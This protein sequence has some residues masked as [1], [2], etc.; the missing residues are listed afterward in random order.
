MKWGLG[1]EKTGN[2]CCKLSWLSAVFAFYA[3]L[4]N[5]SILPLLENFM[6][7]KARW[8][9]GGVG[10]GGGVPPI[11]LLHISWHP[12][13]NCVVPI[14]RFNLFAFLLFFLFSSGNCYHLCLTPLTDCMSFVVILRSPELR[15]RHHTITLRRDKRRRIIGLWFL[16]RTVYRLLV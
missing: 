6:W 12:L 8:S 5:L 3:T 10:G 15:P 1:D 2:Y 7:Q 9:G 16:E 11:I 13:L 4:C 14:C